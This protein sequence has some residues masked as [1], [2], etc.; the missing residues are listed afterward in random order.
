MKLTC[1][2]WF[3]LSCCTQLRDIEM[4][5]MVS[6]YTRYNAL[7]DMYAK[8]EDMESAKRLFD[9]MKENDHISWSRFNEAIQVFPQMQLSSAKPDA[10]TLINLLKL[11]SDLAALDIGRWVHFYMDR[12]KI[13][14]LYLNTALIDM[15]CKCRNVAD[16]IDIFNKMPT[17]NCKDHLVGRHMSMKNF[18]HYGYLNVNIRLSDCILGYYGISFYV[19]MKGRN[20]NKNAMSL[21]TIISRLGLNVCNQHALKFFAAMQRESMVRPDEITFITVLSAYRQAGLVEQGYH[22]FHMMTKS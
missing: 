10:I 18:R 3:Q 21:T 17:K 13:S 14:D 5:N 9:E 15:Y 16:A 22:Y 20:P 4:G 6:D 11:C 8:C 2:R 19:C 12:N 1:N 7:V